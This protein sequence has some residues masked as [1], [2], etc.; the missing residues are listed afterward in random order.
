VGDA[1]IDRD[2]FVAEVGL[3]WQAS[4]TLKLGVAYSGQIGAQSQDHAVK[5]QFELRF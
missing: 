1:P 5:G 2:A 4:D 3:D